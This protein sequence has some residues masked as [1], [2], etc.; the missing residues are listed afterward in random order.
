VRGQVIQ[1]VEN[2]IDFSIWQLKY[3][4]IKRK[5][6][7]V[8]FVYMG[9]LTDSKGVDILLQAFRPV[10][11]KTQAKLEIIGDGSTRATLEDATKRLGLKKNVSFAGWLPQHECAARLSR[12]D[13]F[14][15]PSI[16]EC[17]GAAVLEAM[18]VGLPV[19]A[20]NWGG[21]ADYLD[22]NCGVMVNPTSREEFLG[23]LTDAMLHLA[24]S[25]QLR[26][27]MGKMARQRVMDLYDW[28]KK[29][30]RMMGIYM[31]TIKRA[32]A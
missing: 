11:S 5:S 21:P 31:E 19:I 20:T 8:N 9:R 12:A 14:V 23:S 32:A 3:R 7:D 4:E 25:P 24:R 16:L 1:L 27:R 30:D 28:E 17:G 13:V 10:C 29:V 2:G 18:A 6:N 22:N 26:L 15:L